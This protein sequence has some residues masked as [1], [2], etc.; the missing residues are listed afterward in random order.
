LWYLS[1]DPEPQKDLKTLM[2]SDTPPEENTETAATG[3][4]DPEEEGLGTQSTIEPVGP[5]KRRIKAEVPQGKVEEELDRN[6]KELISSIQ[7]PGFRR[8]H[9]PRRL[10]EKR[11]GG[12]IEG[13]V[14]EALLGMSFGEVVKEKELKVLGKPK[15]DQIHFVKGEPMRYE[16]EVEVW[17]EF[18]LAEYAGIEVEPEPVPDVKPE[19]IDHQIDRLREQYAEL[20]AIERGE[21]TADD[22]F[23]GRYALHRDGIRVHSRD[24]VQ[25][26]P[27]TG[28]LDGFAIPDLAEKVVAHRDAE[29]LKFDSKVP[30][31][32]SEEVLRGTDVQIEFTI[33]ETKRIQLPPA[34]DEL[35]Q[36][37]DAPTIA[38]LRARI[39]KEIEKRLRRASDERIE[40]KVMDRIAEGLKF[41][42]PEGLLQ[43]QLKMERFKLQFALLQEGR[44][45]EEVEEELKKVDEQ[46]AAETF[47]KSFKK[48]FI[49]EKIAEKEKIYATEDEVNLR[50]ALMAQAYGQP[51]RAIWEELEESNRI[52]SLRA[53]IRHSKVRKFLREKAKV[54]GNGSAPAAGAPAETP[55]APAE[56][57]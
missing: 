16:V 43:E 38:E 52:E 15:F 36:R 14:K 42:L 55:I 12:E 8:G 27:K 53:E 1:S 57:Q 32:Y 49:L 2:A 10:I 7:I 33:E 54:A 45:K 17:P 13:D 28:I 3:E 19:E 41:D 24:D 30:P 37:F 48:F 21:A 50:V 20:A 18:E 6:Y 40:A 25:F 46:V 11:Y 34:D 4:V 23:I 31:E 44:T 47:R 29:V 26:R 5:C 56:A 51:T 35:A 39:S 9:V 22:I